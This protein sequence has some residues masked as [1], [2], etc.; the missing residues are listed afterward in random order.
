MS[1]LSRSSLSRSSRST[2]YPNSDSINNGL[3]LT[4]GED[5]DNLPDRVP[6]P[7]APNSQL[8]NPQQVP[9]V[10]SCFASSLPPFQYAPSYR[11][12]GHPLGEPMH[13]SPQATLSRDFYP[14]FEGYR[15]MTSGYEDYLDYTWLENAGTSSYV[16][17]P[18]DPLVVAPSL[19]TP[20]RTSHG[21]DGKSVGMAIGYHSI[22]NNNDHVELANMGLEQSRLGIAAMKS[23][24]YYPASER[25]LLGQDVNAPPVADDKA[26]MQAILHQWPQGRIDVWSHGLGRS[27]PSLALSRT[28]HPLFSVAT[29]V[30]VDIQCIG[31][32][33]LTAAEILS[34]FPR[35]INNKHFQDRFTANGLGCAIIGSFINYQRRLVAPFTLCP[36]TVRREMSFQNDGQTL[37][38]NHFAQPVTDFTAQNWEFSPRNLGASGGRLHDDV[39]IDY[40]L[41][42][43]AAGVPRELWPTGPD[44]GSYTATLVHA[45]NQNHTHVMISQ[46][47]PYIH[48]YNLAAPP[49]PSTPNPDTEFRDRWSPTIQAYHKELKADA[50][51][52]N[53]RMR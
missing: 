48:Q 26:H 2:E 7:L 20:S 11:Y 17:Q 4:Q 21:H 3:T 47:V 29:P 15:D 12:T 51:A 25:M 10:S 33:E 1:P 43:T 5:H 27:I 18:M 28:W 30:S 52:R 14:A 31:N 38:K 53:Y 41:V 50:K 37:Q 9:Q 8:F 42:D 23:M 19:L 49:F 34:F 46:I 44:A 40:R 13:A 36:N 39:P 16:E 32:V 24:G 45:S 22:P 6:A 35:H